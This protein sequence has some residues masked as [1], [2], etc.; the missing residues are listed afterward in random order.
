[1]LEVESLDIVPESFRGDYVEKKDGDKVTFIHRAF[2]AVKEKNQKLEGRLADFDTVKTKLQTIEEQQAKE[3]REREDRKLKGL[4]DAHDYE[5][6]LKLEQEKT[7]DLERRSG[8]TV[9]QYQDRLKAANDK[10]AKKAV[11]S[12]ISEL[13][14][15]AHDDHKAA[16]TRLV[17]SQVTFDPETDKYTFLDDDGGA[18]SLD[19]E[20]F[21]AH[22][23]SSKVYA[24]LIKAETSKGGHGENSRN[25]GGGKVITRAAFENLDPK[26]KSEFMRAGGKLKD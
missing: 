4:R 20:G 12:A 22:I 21:K 9:K 19:L 1:M 16:F 2:V 13:A 8:E 14:A 11:D 24:G 6:L 26:S 23:A 25:A 15:L 3:A 18:T 5:A 17:R 7:Q 10:L